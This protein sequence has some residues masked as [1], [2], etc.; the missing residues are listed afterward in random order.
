MKCGSKLTDDYFE[1]DADSAKDDD[2]DDGRV[3]GDGNGDEF[4]MIMMQQHNDVTMIRALIMS[5]P[6]G[7]RNLSVPFD[8]L[9]SGC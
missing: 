7:A 9:P 8:C 6:D 2:D 1:A 4:A 3:D 5:A